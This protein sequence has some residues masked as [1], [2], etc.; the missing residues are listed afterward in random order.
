L[1]GYQSA[2]IQYKWMIFYS[3]IYI[4]RNWISRETK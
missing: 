2:L 4:I 3:L 1:T